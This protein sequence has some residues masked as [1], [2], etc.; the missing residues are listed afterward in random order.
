ME[1]LKKTFDLYSKNN[2]ISFQDFGSAA[3]SLG[4]PY[5]DA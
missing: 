5:T 3:R 4:I 1:I 2:K